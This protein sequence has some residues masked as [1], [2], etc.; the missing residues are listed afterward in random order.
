MQ[1]KQA[2]SFAQAASRK[3]RDAEH[4]ADRLRVENEELQARFDAVRAEAEQ[5]TELNLRISG[6]KHIGDLFG[7]AQ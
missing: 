4:E 6:A 5:L 3:Q 1:L 2:E 7:G